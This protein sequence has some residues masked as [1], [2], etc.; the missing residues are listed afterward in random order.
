MTDDPTAPTDPDPVADLAAEVDALRRRIDEQGGVVRRTQVSLAQLA[1]SIGKV[2]ESQRRRERRLTLNSFVAYLLFTILLGGGFFVLYQSRA[3]DLVRDR[4]GARSDLAAARKQLELAQGQLQTRDAAAQRAYG[5]FQLLRDGN[6][7]E[8]L[9]R[10]A[11]IAHDALTPTEREVFTEGEK[12]ARG[13][14][15]DAGWSAGVDAFRAGDFPKAVT[16]LKRAVAYETGGANSAQ[17]HYYL[18]VAMVRT[19]D[20]AGA[21]DELTA[22][23][24]GKVDQAGVIDARYWLGAAL[25]GAGKLDQ[26]RREYDKFAS[27]QP[28]SP[29]ATT[30]RRKSAALALKAPTN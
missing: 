4:D 30:A 19:G 2:V 12:V 18:G 11:E 7:S 21:V 29:L 1:E 20:P 15:V 9:A 17:M 14:L 5:F 26:A 23:I 13:K 22:A 10:Y 28:M 25:E 8:A 3:S 27:A 16:E 6:R 24:A